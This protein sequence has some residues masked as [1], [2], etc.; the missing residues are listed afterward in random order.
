MGVALRLRLL[1]VVD[2]IS[3]RGSQ[4]PP[5]LRCESSPVHFFCSDASKNTNTPER[6]L[7]VETEAV[8]LI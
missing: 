6:R 4:A 8:I 7:I 5:S 2:V 3:G 1:S